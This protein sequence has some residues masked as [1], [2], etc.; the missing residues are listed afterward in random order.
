MTGEMIARLDGSLSDGLSTVITGK[1]IM[2]VSPVLMK[3]KDTT[4]QTNDVLLDFI[5]NSQRVEATA[6]LD[7]K[8]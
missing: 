1:K 7:L 3:G 4:P 8:R 2:I 5:V 6:K